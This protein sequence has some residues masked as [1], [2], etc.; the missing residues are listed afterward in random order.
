[1]T[2]DAVRQKI[3]GQQATKALV[4]QILSEN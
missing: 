4:Y 3:N 2:F 1:M